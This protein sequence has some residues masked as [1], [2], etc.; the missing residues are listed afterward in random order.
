[1]PVL[2]SKLLESNVFLWPFQLTNRT[3]LKYVYCRSKF[4]LSP[5]VGLKP[6]RPDCAISC[7]LGDFLNSFCFSS[8]G[9]I[10]S[11]FC[12]SKCLDCFLNFCATFY[13][14]LLFL[15]RFFRF[16]AKQSGHIVSNPWRNLIRYSFLQEGF[17]HLP[18]REGPIRPLE[19]LRAEVDPV[20]AV[21]QAISVA[22]KQHQEPHWEGVHP[23]TCYERRKSKC[24]R[25]E[26]KG[27]IYL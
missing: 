22:A 11:P 26:S 2:L 17:G 16:S 25:W 4:S 27:H 19:R 6:A 9:K 8:V 20:L 21:Q 10:L 24:L 3:I 18:G 12:H 1:M 15:S 23:L 7:P 5:L 14:Y 13:T